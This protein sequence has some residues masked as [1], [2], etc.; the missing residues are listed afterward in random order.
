MNLVRRK[1][2]TAGALIKR[3]GIK[4]RVKKAGYTATM[5]GSAQTMTKCTTKG[6]IAGDEIGRGEKRDLGDGHGAQSL[7]IHQM[8]PQPLIRMEMKGKAVEE[9]ASRVLSPCP[10]P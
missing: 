3:R 10:S 7:Q 8:S 4:R 9:E 6:V 1:G 2:M 5:T